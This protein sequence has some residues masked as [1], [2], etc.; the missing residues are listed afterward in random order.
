MALITCEKCG[1]KVSDRAVACPHCGEPVARSSHRELSH[2]NLDKNSSGT[3]RWIVPALIA[4]LVALSIA[5]VYILINNKEQ[6]QP[7]PAEN[8]LSDTV[9]TAVDTAVVVQKEEIEDAKENIREAVEPEPIRHESRHESSSYVCHSE[10][11]DSDGDDGYDEGIDFDDKSS[12]I[13]NSYLEHDVNEGIKVHVNMSTSNL[14]GEQVKVMCR[15]WFQDGRQIKS[16]DGEYEDSKRQVCTTVNVTPD[17]EECTWNDL[18]LF[19]PYTQIKRVRDWKHLKCRV[20]VFYHGHCLAT[21][22]YMHFGCWLE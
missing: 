8:E 20:E 15:F 11:L 10:Y 17:Y 19:I 4:A 9:A 18:Q 12:T 7:A 13:N 14:L 16:T 3:P 1:K 22:N 2:S 5:I 21:G 6:P